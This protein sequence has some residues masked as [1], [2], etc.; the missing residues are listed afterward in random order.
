MYIGDVVF[1]FFKSRKS[2]F[3]Y[4]ILI[5]LVKSSFLSASTP[6]HTINLI[7]A[8]DM[9]E[10]SSATKSGY[11][12]IAHLLKQ[13][14]KKDLPTFF[15]FGGGSIGPSMLSTFDRGSHIIDLLNAIEPDVMATT[16]RD[17]S[18]F[19][20]ELSLRSY[21][22]AFPFVATNIVR[23]DTTE[24]LNGL[25]PYVI[26]QQ[27]NYKIAVLSTLAATA[28]NEYN[29]KQIDILSKVDSVKKQ[30]SLIKE[31]VDLIV[32]MNAGI[33]NDV[34]SLL[35]DGTVN[36]IIQKDSYAHIREGQAIPNHP[37]YVFLH[38]IDEIALINLSWEG[39]DTNRLTL[40]TRVFNY[41]SLAKDSQ[42]QLMVERYENRLSNLLDEV[43]GR[44]LTP[45]NTQR[46]VIR[47]SESAF[48]NLLADTL[49]AYTDADIGLINGGTIRGERMY[50]ANQHISRKDIISEL[51]YRSN[52]VLLSVTGAQLSQAIEHGLSGLDNVLG[53]FLQ[54]SG[55]TIEFNSE[56]AVGQRVITIKHKGKPIQPDALY[57]VA[58]SDYLAKG[59]DNFVMWEKAKKLN[60]KRQNNILLSDILVNYIRTKNDISP[61]ITNRII[62]VSVPHSGDNP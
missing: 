8:N 34:I 24:P 22:A 16:K 30:V 61:A 10:I 39:K 13:E 57:K 53:S 41:S 18:F 55:L 36:L 12:S 58:M 6:T 46:T 15:F 20:D 26:T 37:Q 25:L 11:A 4:F 47:K 62:D 52:A 2:V 28:I 49:K 27:G 19:E 31:D 48:G 33:E 21:E 17:F 56:N 54:V 43:I 45:M 38:G 42:V 29:L 35:E 1:M 40:D 32:L 3:S 51:P 23:K 14:R 59:G 5:L 44:T 60:Y 7:Y 50:K 9:N